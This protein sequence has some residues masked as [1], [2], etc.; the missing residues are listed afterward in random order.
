[1]RG[2]HDTGAASASDFVTGDISN[3]IFCSFSVRSTLWGAPGSSHGDPPFLPVSG[4]N[5][6]CGDT[7]IRTRKCHVWNACRLTQTGDKRGAHLLGLLPDMKQVLIL[8]VL[9][10]QKPH[11][12]PSGAFDVC[13]ISL[14]L[15]SPQALS[16]TA[17]KLEP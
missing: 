1:M 6:G 13:K 7:K 16:I 8:L 9:S 2:T 12:G 17:S 15:S 11:E 14:C 3:L 5:V 4:L 10:H